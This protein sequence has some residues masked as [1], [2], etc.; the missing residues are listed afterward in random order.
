[1]GP[2]FK[3]GS[4]STFL[5]LA[6]GSCWYIAAGEGTVVTSDSRA[7]KEDTD[8]KSRGSRHKPRLTQAREGLDNCSILY[9]IQDVMRLYFPAL[10]GKP[11][12]HPSTASEPLCVVDV[13]CRLESAAPC[14][15]G[16][17]P[18]S[19]TCPVAKSHHLP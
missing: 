3:T 1:M 17:R 16:S 12:Q 14:G 4:L 19:S 9:C 18:W 11:H 7:A 10:S 6:A 13:P 8:H 5:L 2:L 15:T